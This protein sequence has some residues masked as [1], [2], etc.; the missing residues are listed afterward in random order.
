MTRV[1]SP[2]V[3]HA[4]PYSGLRPKIYAL[5]DTAVESGIAYGWTRA[6]KHTDTP[7]EDQIKDEIHRAVM[8]DIAEWFEFD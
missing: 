4:R 8:N 7:T 3:Q 6:H 1:K 2:T 5:L